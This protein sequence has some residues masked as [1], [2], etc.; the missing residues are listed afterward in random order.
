LDW[1]N[2]LLIAKLKI[3]PFLATLGILFIGQSVQR[4]TTNGGQPIYLTTGDYAPDLLGDLAFVFPRPAD[5]G[6]GCCSAV[7]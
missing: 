4:L 2:A 1:P 5:A 7:Y 6:C 3:S